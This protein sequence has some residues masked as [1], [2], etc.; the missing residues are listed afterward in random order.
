METWDE[1]I[2]CRAAINMKKKKFKEGLGDGSANTMLPTQKRGP[3]FRTAAHAQS[4]R[5]NVLHV[6]SVGRQRQAES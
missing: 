1:S 5:H 2:T 4:V 3:G 6:L